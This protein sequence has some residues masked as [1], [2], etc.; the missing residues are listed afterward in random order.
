MTTQISTTYLS[1]SEEGD[2]PFWKSVAVIAGATLGMATGFGSLI[3]PSMIIVPIGLEFGW[4]KSELSFCYTLAAFGMA[5]GG[6]VWGR[7]SD[8]LD[9]RYLLWIGAIFMIVPMLMMARA[10]ELWQLYVANAMLGCAG[11]GCLYPALVSAAGDWFENRRGLV[12]GIVTAG[13]AVGQGLMPFIADRLFDHI[14]WRSTFDVI[15][16]M[17]LIIQ[18]LVVASVRRRKPMAADAPSAQVATRLSIFATPRIA[19]LSAAAFL[20]CACMGV[21]L[22]HLV[23]Y[24]NA[25]CSGSS[26]LGATSLLVA[27]TSGA[28]GRVCFGVFADRFGSLP[29][30]AGASFLQSVCVLAFPALQSEASII[31]LSAVFGFG[32]AGNMTC[33]ILCVRKEAPAAQFGGAIGLVMFVAWLGM[34]VGGYLGGAL[35]DLTGAYGLSF[36]IAAAFGAMNLMV[37]GVLR[38]TNATLG[39][40]IAQKFT[41]TAG[42]RVAEHHGKDNDAGIA[43][44]FD[45]TIDPLALVAG[46]KL[47]ARLT[48]GQQ[49]NILAAPRLAGILQ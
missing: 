6:L 42:G 12:M 31:V 3:L 26:G 27:M 18:Y 37:L 33:L 40:A 11:F 39:K 14:G 43:Q 29:S 41:G 13:G 49:E 36:Q 44:R 30:Y 47:L 16:A 46:A 45:L 8:R 34:G 4:S 9:I 38:L 24:V 2:N 48:V 20:C 10:N 35:F 28:V 15:A 32:F 21:P 23:G 19:A 17:L 1:D 22:V 7:V 25:V 5:V